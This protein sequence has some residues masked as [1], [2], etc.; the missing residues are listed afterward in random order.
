[1]A[2]NILLMKP[3]DL[4][5]LKL[6]LISFGSISGIGIGVLLS[7]ILHSNTTKI[8]V[9]ISFLGIGVYTVFKNIDLLR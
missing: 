2:N 1:M 7:L 8:I 4:N 9:G 3:G 6:S 5:P